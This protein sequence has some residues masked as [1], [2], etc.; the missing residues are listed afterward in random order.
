MTAINEFRRRRLVPGILLFRNS[1]ALIAA[2]ATNR[3]GGL[4][5]A[6]RTLSFGLGYSDPI[7]G[8]HQHFRETDGQ[9]SSWMG[10]CR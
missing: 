8:G 5:E 3:L 2:Y 1:P 4:N 10:R 6:A 9:G 7:A